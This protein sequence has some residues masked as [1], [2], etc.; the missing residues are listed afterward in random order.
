[1]LLPSRRSRV[2][3]AVVLLLTAAGCG[4]GGPTGDIDKIQ[5]TPTPFEITVINTAGRALFDVVVEIMPAGPASH[6]TATVP[7]IENGEKRN[8]SHTVFTDRDGVRFSLRNV[9]VSGVVVTAKD[10]DGKTFKVE[11]PWKQ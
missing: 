1:M 8:L 7:R 4:G 3:M 6:F 2:A 9:K 11:V 5:V 10:M